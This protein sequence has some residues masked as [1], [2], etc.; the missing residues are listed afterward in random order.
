MK[1][2]PKSVPAGPPGRGT[3]LATVWQI[4]KPIIG[5][6]P[7]MGRDT[8]DKKIS[9]M[10]KHHITRILELG[11][12]RHLANRFALSVEVFPDVATQKVGCQPLFGGGVEGEKAFVAVNFAQ[13]GPKNGGVGLGEFN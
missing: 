13:G 1:G 2:K 10:A 6:I 12:R 3:R 4:R 8:V 5:P 9:A 11:L 7:T